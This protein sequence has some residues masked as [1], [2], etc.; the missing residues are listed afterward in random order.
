M[1]RPLRDSSPAEL[2][3]FSD[4]TERL[5][6]FA[7][8]VHA[9]WADGWLTALAT[10]LTLPPFDQWIEAMAGDAFDRAFADPEAR[11]PAEAALLARLSV[12]RDQLDAETLDEDPDQLRLAPVMIEWTAEDRAQVQAERELSD[13]EAALLVTGA[14]WA[15]GFIAAVTS[16]L[17]DWPGAE[18]EAMDDAMQLLQQL[19]ALRLAEGSDELN[20]HVQATYQRDT[21]ERDVLID[22]ACMAAQDLRLWAVDHA[23]RPE[24][25]RVEKT[26]GRNDPCPCGSGKKFKKCHG[27]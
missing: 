10:G 1:T 27:A 23:P 3:A 6:G 9:E 22:T 24:T 20:A 5:G 2:E 15:E 11:A 4:V 8:E 18:Q 26:P 14:E 12:L 7:P 16:K 25:R 13:E 21:V 19:H 17:V